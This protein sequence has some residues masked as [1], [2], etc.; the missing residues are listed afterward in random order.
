MFYPIYISGLSGNGKTFMVEQACAK[1]NKEFIRVQINPETDED[2]LILS[3]IHISEPTRPERNG[4]AGV[5][6]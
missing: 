4:F 1:L 3:L 6:V 5:L 2:D